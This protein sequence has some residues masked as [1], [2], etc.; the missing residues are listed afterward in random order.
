MRSP[1]V[2]VI[3]AQVIHTSTW[4]EGDS[5]L[6]DIFAPPRVDF[7]LKP[8]WVRNDAEYPMPKTAAAAE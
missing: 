2:T 3:P 8:G 4:G 1:S 7:S 6:V 5:Q